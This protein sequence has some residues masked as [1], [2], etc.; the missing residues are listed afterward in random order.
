MIIYRSILISLYPNSPLRAEAEGFLNDFI[1]YVS[2]QVRIVK[3]LKTLTREKQTRFGLTVDTF[4]K[5]VYPSLVQDTEGQRNRDSEK[6]I[7]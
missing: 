2:D 6:E 4:L 5:T 1:A 3:P 7:P